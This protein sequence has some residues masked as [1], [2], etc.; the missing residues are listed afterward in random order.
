MVGEFL[1]N[2]FTGG[3]RVPGET[4][5]ATRMFKAIKKA[6][7]GMHTKSSVVIKHLYS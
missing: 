4:S 7:K 6:V 2:C 3:W 5:V 1:E